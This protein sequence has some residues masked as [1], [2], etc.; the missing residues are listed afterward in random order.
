MTEGR[1]KVGRPRRLEDAENYL[2]EL[3]VLEIGAKKI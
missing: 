2:R 1:I 3:K